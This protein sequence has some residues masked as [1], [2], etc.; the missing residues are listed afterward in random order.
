MTS[1]T[2]TITAEDLLQLKEDL[3]RI[4]S[5]SDAL[6]LAGLSEEPGLF[7][8]QKEKIQ[9][10]WEDLQAWDVYL[11]KIDSADTLGIAPFVSSAF[12]SISAADNMFARWEAL[13]LDSMRAFEDEGHKRL[14]E[15]HFVNSRRRFVDLAREAREAA[16]IAYFLVNLVKIKPEEGQDAKSP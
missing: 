3:L 5:H 7:I 13:G 11:K 12:W 15:K 16:H 4:R 14:I 2:T 10:L 1:S 6:R 9:S 8:Q